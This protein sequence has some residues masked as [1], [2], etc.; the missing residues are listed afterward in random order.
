MKENRLTKG[1]KGLISIII[2]GL[3]FYWIITA[4]YQGIWV[5]IGF[6]FV[7]AGWRIWKQRESFLSALRTFETMI[8]GKPLDKEYWNPGEWKSR[9]KRKIKFAWRKD[10]K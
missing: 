10:K 8:W 2:S 3:M 9:K 4:W 7:Y 5:F 6:V 1:L